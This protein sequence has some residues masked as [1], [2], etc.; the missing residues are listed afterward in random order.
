MRRV[1]AGRPGRR[2]VHAATGQ[3]DNT[4]IPTENPSGSH[5]GELILILTYQDTSG[6][7]K[8][9]LILKAQTPPEHCKSAGTQL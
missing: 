8:G 4:H 9:D 3:Q 7:V 1:C 5:F 6:R 2:R